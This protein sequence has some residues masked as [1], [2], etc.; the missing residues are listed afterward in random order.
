M[1]EVVSGLKDGE[2]IISGPFL[3]VSKKLNDGDKVTLKR[4]KKLKINIGFRVI[5]KE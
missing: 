4:L 3:E 1:I 5:R 2:E